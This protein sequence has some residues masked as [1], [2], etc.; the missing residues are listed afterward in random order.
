MDGDHNHQKRCG[1]ARS[2]KSTSSR[3]RLSKARAAKRPKSDQNSDSTELT[4]PSTSTSDTG[5]QPIRNLHTDQ[6][7]PVSSASKRKLPFVDLEVS[8]KRGCKDTDHQE[9]ELEGYR[10][11]DIAIIANI[12]SSQS[13]CKVCYAEQVQL[14]ENANARN[15]FVASLCLTCLGCGFEHKFYTSPRVRPTPSMSQDGND[16]EKR[17][18]KTMFDLN[19]R[20]A[21]AF[22]DNGRGL[23]AMTTFC[24]GLNMPPPMN[25]SSFSE[26]NKKL[27]NAAEAVATDSMN[28]AAAEV[29]EDSG[30]T[31]SSS[32]PVAVNTTAM[33][34]GTWQK[35]GHS[36]LTGAVTCISPKNSKILQYHA[37]NKT[38][39]ACS[40]KKNADMNSDAYEMWLAEH[41]PH[42]GKNYEGSAPAMEPAG[43]KQIFNKSVEERGLRY[44]NYIG[45]G[46]TKSFKMVADSK[47]Y[48]DEITITKKE[49]VG[50]VQ[51]RVGKALRDLKKN[52]GRSKLSDGKTMGGRGRLTDK[53]IDQLQIYYGLAI[54]RN[55]GNLP[56]MKSDIKAILNHRQSTDTSPRHECCPPG[57]DSWCGYQRDISLET[58]DHKH[59]HPLPIAIVEAIQPVFER[60]SNTN[61]LSACLDGYTQNA[62]E[63]ANAVIWKRCPKEVFASYITFRAAVA[64]GVVSYNDGQTGILSIMDKLGMKPGRHASDAYHKIDSIRVKQSVKRAQELEKK[65]RV[66]IRQTRKK[67]EETQIDTEG[68]TYLAGGF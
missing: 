67:Q 27:K 14:K 45:D 51:K 5:T 29:R 2:K 59:D 63:S 10:L 57:P 28:R 60:L 34:D 64:M 49:C 7:E 43:V 68:V 37:M 26:I 23:A 13:V 62:A 47:P 50:H 56:K 16:N 53:E 1:K 44:V 24:G 8:S 40:K 18:H 6:V 25:A 52:S 33:F 54:R 20:M 35:R 38:C 21:L 55:K 30:S 19:A 36:S 31:S 42:C 61:L 15:G 48:G 66:T 22:R 58:N 46:D 65:K 39:T 32:V 17:S 41:S 4:S 11:I 12:I 3:R 9:S